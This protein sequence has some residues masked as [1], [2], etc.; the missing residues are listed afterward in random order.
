MFIEALFII[1][2]TWKQP[3]HPSVGEWINK[4][5][6][7][8]K[9]EYHLALKGKELSRSATHCLMLTIWHFGKGKTMED[10][11]KIRG[12]QGW[13]QREVSRQSTEDF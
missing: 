9:M 10:S 4:L 11:E 7:I 2:I 12:C 5:W 1:V 3:R 13:W 6:Y 8:Q